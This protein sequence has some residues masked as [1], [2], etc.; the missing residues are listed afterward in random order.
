LRLGF[1]GQFLQLKG[2]GVL[3]N[4]MEILGREMG[5][6]SPHLWVHGTS[7]ELQPPEFQQT[8]K[9]L[10]DRTRQ[11]VTFVGRY[12]PAH[13]PQLMANVDWVIVPSIWWE[14]A[15]LVIQEAF[16]HGRPVICS[17]IGGMA[18]KVVDG[19]NGVHFHAGDPHSL[20]E[21]LRRSVTTDGLWGQLV[22]GIPSV[23]TVEAHVDTLSQLYSSLLSEQPAPEEIYATR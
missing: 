8:F 1:F 16:A 5:T 19:V 6:A 18:E 10:I 17:D 11:N 22:A 20:A 2:I 21:A 23:H 7:L 12:D 4:A 9:S 13:L 15:P 14:N 3:L